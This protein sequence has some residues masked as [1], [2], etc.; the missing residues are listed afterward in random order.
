MNSEYIRVFKALTDENRIRVLELLCEGEQC[1]CVLLDDLK[2][3]QP[4]LSHHM[5]ILCDSGLVVSR[6]EGKWN[7]YSINDSGCIYASELLNSLKEKKM[8]DIVKF[9]TSYYH[10]FKPV[11]AFCKPKTSEEKEAESMDCSCSC[12]K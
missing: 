9:M 3:K 2:I 4:T 7:Y 10:I 8:T 12:M 6:K 1:A 11:K 5:K